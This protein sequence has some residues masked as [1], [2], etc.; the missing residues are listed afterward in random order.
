MS[1]V[2]LKGARVIDAAQGIDKEQ[3][4]I[5]E[6]GKIRALEKPGSIPALP[7]ATVHEVSGHWVVPGLIDIHV[8]LREPGFEWKETIESGCQAA[9]LGG[10]TTVCSM[11]NTRPTN[12]SAEVTKFILQQAQ[13]A[14]LARVLPIGSVTMGLKGAELAP[15]SELYHAGCV[16]FSDDGEP[17]ANAGLM[18]RALEWASVH[19]LTISCHEED[20]NL[21]CGG[22]MN[23]SPL[24]NRMGLSGWPKVAE[25]VM[26]ARD[27]ELARAFNGRVHICHVTTARGVELVRRGKNDGIRVTAEVSP[28]HLTLTQNDIGEYDTNYKMSPPLRE[29]EDVAALIAGIKDGTL[30]AIASDHAPHEADTKQVE[31]QRAS[32]G[33][34]GLQTTIPLIMNFVAQGILTPLKAIELLTSGPARCFSLSGGTLKPGALADV[35]VINPS[36]VWRFD[37]ESCASLSYNSPFMKKDLIGKAELVFVGGKL[38]VAGGALVNEEKN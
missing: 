7:G 16:A 28:H 17:I 14:A 21:T 4:I 12:D 13:K 19:G 27:I 38:V 31:F 26:I 9:V 29:A 35:S 24:S 5:I 34:L 3:D 6:D 23:E 1:T 36:A 30:D 32:F 20:K 25:E 8:H 18:R 11:P 2:V 22:C 15:L 33:I 37:R 10:V